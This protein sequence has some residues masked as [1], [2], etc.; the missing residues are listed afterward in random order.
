MIYL[1]G[2]HVAGRAGSFA[3]AVMWILAPRP[4]D[5]AELVVNEPFTTVLVL[6]VTG[7]AIARAGSGGRLSAFAIGALAGLLCLVRVTHVVTLVYVIPLALAL[8]RHHRLRDFSWGLLGFAPFV[9]LI[10]VFQAALDGAW[11][12]QGYDLW[13]P[14]AT[15]PGVGWNWRYF[16][17]ADWPG[18]LPQSLRPH[19]QTHPA[20][21]LGL[22]PRSYVTVMFYPWP[23]AAGVVWTMLEERRAL[24]R[25]LAWITLAAAGVTLVVWSL[26]YFWDPRFFMP[27]MPM[28]TL[29]GA[30]ALVPRRRE[31]WSPRN[32]ARAGL[33]AL[34]LWQ[35]VAV[36]EFYMRHQRPWAISERRALQTANQVIPANAL[37]VIDGRSILARSELGS[38]R[39]M[40]W[41]V[42][43]G[44]LL[45]AESRQY[46]VP[47]VRPGDGRSA[48]LFVGIEPAADALAELADA[49]RD[50]RSAVVLLHRSSSDNET[51][52]LRW[53]ALERAQPGTRERLAMPGDP[54]Y[55][56][57]TWRPAGAPSP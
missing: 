41:A 11:W 47:P 2:R 14:Y 45:L 43:G 51:Q 1:V 29:L 46:D 28:V 13:A 44:D 34:A 39:V 17:L 56:A 9:A 31:G 19:W 49:A 50:G 42:D 40:N 10:A 53:T 5:I 36:T 52:R 21:L 33:L 4:M 35:L 3:A 54:I 7:L 6:A 12:R 55:Q 23:V 48:A 32:L 20:M 22:P 30:A 26:Y 18:R 27:L 24:R 25:R 8:Q 57:W 15:A 37:V 16:A 38:R